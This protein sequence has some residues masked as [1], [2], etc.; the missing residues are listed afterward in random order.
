MYRS[1]S[2]NTTPRKKGR[3]KLLDCDPDEIMLVSGKTGEGVIELLQ[4]IIDRV[5]QPES[6]I[7]ITYVF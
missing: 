6:K 2:K 4:E 5:P 1:V 3:V 7:N